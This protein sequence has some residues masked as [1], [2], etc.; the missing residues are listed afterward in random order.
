[1]NTI[2][3]YP[4]HHLGSAYNGGFYSYANKD[5]RTL[6]AKQKRNKKKNFIKKIPRNARRPESTAHEKE[7]N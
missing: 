6:L 2:D 1:M 4:N 3:D 7:K 5:L